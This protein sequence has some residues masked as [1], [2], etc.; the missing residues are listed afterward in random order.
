MASILPMTLLG[1]NLGQRH[2]YLNL[3]V[4]RTAAKQVTFQDIQ[5]LPEQ[6]AIDRLFKIDL[7]GKLK[8]AEYILE[9]LKDDD[10]LYVS[11]A[12]KCKWLLEQH[13]I[14]NPKYL[15]D[16][17]FPAMVIPAISRMK[18]WLYINLKD[19]QR[20]EEFY[21]YYRD[22]KFEYA[23]KFL[24]HCDN[25]YVLKEFPQLLIKITPHYLK[26]F[27]EKNPMLIKLYFDSLATDI[28]LLKVYLKNQYLYYNN[29]KF[30]LKSDP[31]LFLDIIEK[32][33]KIH[34]FAKLSPSATDY[35]MRNY[36]NRFMAKSELYVAHL[37]HMPTVVRYLSND[38]CQDIVLRLARADYMSYWFSYENVELLVKRVGNE[39]RAAFKKKVFIEKNVGERVLE[40]PY[41]FP[42][43]PILPETDDLNMNVFHDKEQT[44]I[45]Y[46]RSYK[47]RP[48]M[49][50]ACTRKDEI[51]FCS[52]SCP[53]KSQLQMLFDE[54]RVIGF[55]GT[56]NE[57]KTRVGTVSNADRRRDMLLVLVS[58]SGGRVESVRTLMQLALKLRNEPVH[59]RATIV[60]SLVK[61]ASAWRLP[62]DVWDM[63][64]DYGVGLGLNGTKPEAECR[65]GLHAVV[66]RQLLATGDCEPTVRIAFFSDFSTLSEYKL[67]VIERTTI[68]VAL[69]KILIAA[70]SSAKPEV[71]AGFLNQL[72][73]VLN[74]YHINAGSSTVVSAVT[75][76]AKSDPILARP[77]LRRLYEARVGRR[78]LI[79][80]YLQFRHDDAALVNILR[81]DLKALD[82][83]W[84][85]K[86]L[87]DNETRGNQF[88]LKSNVYFNEKGGIAE[89]IRLAIQD[90]VTKE[91][92]IRLARP[93]ATLTCGRN[94]QLMLCEEGKAS[95]ECLKFTAALRANMHRSRPAPDVVALGWNKVGMKAFAVSAMRCRPAQITSLIEML[96]KEGAKRTVR[97]IL[98]LAQR[99]DWVSD[100]FKKVVTV[101][102]LAALRAAFLYFRSCG[103]EADPQI[104]EIV[105][106][107]LIDADLKTRE[108]LRYI[109]SKVEWV[110]KRLQPDYYAVLYL[111]LNK[112][113]DDNAEEMLI[114]LMTVLPEVS[115][116]LL[117]QVLI[118]VLENMNKGIPESYPAII[119]RYLMLSKNMEEHNSRFKL[120]VDPFLEKIYTYRN[121]GDELR[122]RYFQNNLDQ[123]M[124]CLQY[125]TAFFDVKYQ[126]C[127]QVIERVLEWIRTF[128]PKDMYFK[129]YVKVHA[130]MIYFKAIRYSLKHNSEIFKDNTRKLSEGVNI[131][132][133]TFGKYIAE[134]VAEL[135][136][137][138]FDSVL[139]I[140][141]DAFIEY[142][143]DYIV[144]CNGK[145]KFTEAIIKGML[146]ESVGN[147]TRL[148]IHVLRSCRYNLDDKIYNEIKVLAWGKGDKAVQFF[149]NA[150]R[151]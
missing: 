140:Y 88:I 16:V 143:R 36:K 84:F 129:R 64:L 9:T 54:F 78:E 51:M 40:C 128:L 107:F 92:N 5:A 3:L 113:S 148:G 17:L 19:P 7:A 28:E 67:T 108:G 32:Y 52:Q 34:R 33:H 45:K 109:V 137:K 13:D 95:R 76:L 22:T 42:K 134:E 117:V 59:Q 147:E 138:Y 125:N 83:D 48:L 112:I 120:F 43:S 133:L 123:I 130:T 2:Q 135:M 86:L 57:L 94:L 65:E 46:K 115:D 151:Y 66:L 41:K 77:L 29:I 1:D 132:G 144:Y 131:V 91:S 75:E 38:E 145:S 6:T 11:R 14:I 18:H 53:V 39:N 30:I 150:E 82:I 97:L 10:M 96:L 37:L 122:R 27:A 139:E 61:R 118:R 116:A 103:D 24:I 74:D 49:R 100:I 71:T 104:W 121:S 60:R 63:I 4:N 50:Y 73:D 23:I 136:S 79:R 98:A 90:N 111:T 31:D 62:N 85:V 81:H 106:P 93:L 149:L 80:H 8:N 99:T 68:S 101:R 55:E 142:M 146:I 72:L 126:S 141:S 47:Y 102:P 89:K 124:E 20:C 114:N 69:Q 58:K 110:P 56:Y 105:K 70:A 87:I 12:L 26:V 15:E 21:Q 35:I 119:I 44:P 127:I 25:E